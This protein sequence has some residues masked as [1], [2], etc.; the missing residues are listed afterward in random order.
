MISLLALTLSPDNVIA[1][2]ECKREHT[3][4]VRQRKRRFKTS[5]TLENSVS[6]INH[7][8]NVTL[9][10]HSLSLAKRSTPCRFI[11]ILTFPSLFRVEDGRLY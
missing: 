11:G 3:K 4:K 7:V 1:G 6:E 9:L 2:Y 5:S 8:I 10:D